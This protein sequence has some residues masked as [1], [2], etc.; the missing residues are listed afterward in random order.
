M[1]VCQPS[2]SDKLQYHTAFCMLYFACSCVSAY[3]F[4]SERR[5]LGFYSW[6][7]R[8]SCATSSPVSR[9]MG[10]RRGGALDDRAAAGERA[11]LHAA[12]AWL[13]T[14]LSPGLTCHAAA[15]H[16]L[17]ILNLTSIS[18][19]GSRLVRIC[20]ALHADRQPIIVTISC[21]LGGCN[22]T[23]N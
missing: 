19:H 7:P 11:A 22:V 9:E 1:N 12:A 13:S 10:D 4:L 18:I 23:D 8:S 15:Q 6:T 17:R 21:I 2:S 14:P 20:R 3:V 5:R 16:G